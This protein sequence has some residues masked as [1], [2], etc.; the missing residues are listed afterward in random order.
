MRF[1][2]WPINI[3]TMIIMAFCHPILSAPAPNTVSDVQANIDTVIEQHMKEVGLVGVG[4]AVIVNKHVAWTKGYGFAD[5]QQSIPFT[6]NTIMNIGSVGKTFTGVALM[7]AVQEGKLSLDAD[8]NTYLPFKVVNPYFPSEK[9]TLRQLATHSSSISDRWSVYANSYYFG[10]DPLESLASFL[11]NYF[12]VGGKYYDKENFHNAKPG[13]FHEYSNIASGLA[14]YVVEMATGKTLSAY[15]HQHIFKPLKMTNTG[16]FLSEIDLTKHSQL[17]VSQSGIAIPIPLYGVPTYPDSGIRSSINDLSTF[18]IALLNEGESNGV[19]M[20][21]KASANEM[22]RLQ[23]DENNKPDNLN[24]S[25]S[26]WGLFWKTKFNTTLIGNGGSDPGIKTEMLA[27]HEKDLAVIVF[28]NTG[29]SG[30]DQRAYASIFRALW[31]HGEALK[32]KP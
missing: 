16:W 2:N 27:N 19:R 8:I 23:F 25:E 26:N 12:V 24:L 29:L 7:R 6:T 17:Y 9:I 1:K 28:F 5:K 3:C 21:E 10:S 31:V 18:F 11:K 14:G 4:A 32:A 13:H 20:L 30:K 22:T 15:T